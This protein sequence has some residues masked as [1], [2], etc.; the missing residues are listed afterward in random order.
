METYR[1]DAL[2]GAGVHDAFLQD[3]Q[4]H[5]VRGVLRG[6]HYQLHRP[7]AKLCRVVQGEVL[8]VAVDIR[9]GSPHFGKWVG[10]VL[11]AENHHALYIPQGFAHGFVVLS[12]SADFLYKCSDY[13]DPADDYGVL[14]ND[15]ALA[16]DWI[17]PLPV[18]SVKDQRNPRLGEVPRDCLPVYKP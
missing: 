2:A 13:F 16:I 1:T 5:S 8:D 4:S 11:A 9:A 10:A 7:Q 3:N 14:W 17:V 6:L 12:E 15:P 18:L